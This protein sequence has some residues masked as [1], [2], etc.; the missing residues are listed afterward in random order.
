MMSN[1]G[2][3]LSAGCL[4]PGYPLRGKM[5]QAEFVLPKGTKLEGVILKAELE[6]K[7][8]RHPVMGLSSE[9]QMSREHRP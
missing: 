4:D 3:D 7:G 9:G 6:V 5:R 8:V 1:E 2:K